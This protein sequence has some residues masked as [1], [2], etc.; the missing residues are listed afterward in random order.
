MYLTD[1]VVHVH[2]TVWTNLHHDEVR[3][4]LPWPEV[5]VRRRRPR[6]ARRPDREVARRRWLRH[7]SVDDYRLRARRDAPDIDH[8][9]SGSAVMSHFPRPPEIRASIHDPPRRQ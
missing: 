7:G 5:Q 6:R 9:Y 2:F 1:G 8:V 3:Y 4:R